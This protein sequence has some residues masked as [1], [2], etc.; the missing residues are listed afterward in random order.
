M[1]IQAFDNGLTVAELKRLIAD[2]PETNE[3]G[4]PTEVW[5]SRNE[6]ESNPVYE[7]S[8]L[9]VKVHDDGEK[10]FDILFS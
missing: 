2:W 8:P 9:N 1:S 5:I 10:S 3:D 6:F 7:V 4:D